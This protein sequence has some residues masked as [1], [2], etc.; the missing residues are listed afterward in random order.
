MDYHFTYSVCQTILKSVYENFAHYGRL[1]SLK[2]SQKTSTQKEPAV[3]CLSKCPFEEI[4]YLIY[5]NLSVSSLKDTEKKKEQKEG[6]KRNG[7]NINEDE[8]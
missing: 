8:V 7:N 2:A 1:C 6:R 3:R 4:M 5:L